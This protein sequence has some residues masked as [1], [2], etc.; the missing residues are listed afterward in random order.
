MA[1]LKPGETQ[2]CRGIQLGCLLLCGLDCSS[3]QPVPV[4]CGPIVQSFGSVTG[5]SLCLWLW[6]RVCDYYN[7]QSFLYLISALSLVNFAIS[8]LTCWLLC[9]MYFS[10]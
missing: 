4:C 8:L 5:L 6:P 10:R 2:C 9:D 7:G 3:A 1:Y